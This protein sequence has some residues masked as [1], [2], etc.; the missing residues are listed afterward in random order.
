MS[1]TILAVIEK[2]SWV[3]QHIVN[4]LKVMGHEV[5]CYYIG[6]YVGEFY[7]RSRKQ[8]QVEKNKELFS[9]ARELRNEQG[10]DL[11]FCY[12][13]DNFLMEEYAKKIAN[14][15]V[16]MVNYNVD[17]PSQWFRQIKTA[18]YFDYML[19]AQQQHMDSL[20]KYSRKVYYFPMAAQEMLPQ[21]DP[22]FREQDEDVSFFG[23]SLPFRQHILSALA[24]EDFSLA[25]YGK[26]WNEIGPLTII[27]SREKT[28]DDFIHY[29]WPR[30]KNER[31]YFIKQVFLDR[32]CAKEAKPVESI[33]PEC[34]KGLLKNEDI[35]SLL[36]RSKINLGISRF[37]GDNLF[38]S[39]HC[40][41][42]LRDFE[43]PMSGGFYLVEKSPGYD[44]AFQD[45]K[46]VVT[47]ETLDDLRE[48]INYYL[49]HAKERIEIATAGQKRAMR[50]HSWRV[51]FEKLFD[52]L[53]LQ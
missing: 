38:K 9:T 14:L 11:I 51:R 22:H 13:Y 40:Q 37:H 43:V 49:Y 23:T 21:E 4:S 48:K 47:W 41:M 19:C 34:I 6:E 39:G 31:S 27:R 7:A 8:T 36:K 44:N 25:I 42:K 5:S 3:E 2:N 12:V 26:Y 32:L 53:Q 46:E 18:R 50:D 35:V 24:K 45:G 28:I 16:C 30:F 17:M 33:P 1:L 15:G 10:L 20:L 52:E 29:G